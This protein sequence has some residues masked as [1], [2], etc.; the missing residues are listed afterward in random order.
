MCFTNVPMSHH[1]WTQQFKRI[2]KW[3]V[4]IFFAASIGFSVPVTA[5]LNGQSILRGLA[6]GAAPGIL[7]KLA[8]GLAARL[9]YKSAEQKRLAAKASPF[10][11]GGTAQPLQYLVGCAMIARGEFAFLVAQIAAGMQYA[12]NE[13]RVAH[14]SSTAPSPFRSALSCLYT[15]RASTC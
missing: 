6:I 15:H 13:V 5:M 2:N 1:I 8:S 9:P 10:T 3:L 4:R 7:C 12:D 14:T 11:C